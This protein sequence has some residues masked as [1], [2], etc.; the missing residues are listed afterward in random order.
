M[1]VYNKPSNFSSSVKACFDFARL[2]G[3]GKN[4][5]MLPTEKLIQS[6]T[7]ILSEDV[8]AISVFRYAN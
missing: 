2:I 3:A 8:E 4:S 6:M 7:I 5:E 1:P